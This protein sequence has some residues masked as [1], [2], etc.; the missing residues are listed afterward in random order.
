LDHLAQQGYV[1]REGSRRGGKWS[2]VQPDALLDEWARRDVWPRRVVVRQYSILVPVLETAAR[3]LL[4]AFGSSRLAF[5][6]WFAAQ[7]RHP[8]TES[9]VLSAYVEALPSPDVLKALNARE[10]ASGG[11]LWLIHPQDEGVFQFAQ[12]IGGLPLVSDAQIYLDLLQAGQRGPDAA[13][14]LRHWEDFRR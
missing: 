9:P 12:T 11:R 14:A 1:R 2:V 10:V 3:Q 6:Q 4:T 5:T 8:Y 13:D 7:L